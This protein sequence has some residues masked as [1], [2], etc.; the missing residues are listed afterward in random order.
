MEK[1]LETLCAEAERAVDNNI[2]IIIL[3]DRGVNRHLVPIPMLLATGAIHHHLI[4]A[5]KRMKV[6][7]ICETGEARDVH[8]FACLLGYGA[9]AVNPYL[10]LASLRNLCEQKIEVPNPALTEAEIAASHHRFL[11]AFKNY[12]KALDEGILK[13]M[14]KMGISTLTSYRGAQIF[15]AI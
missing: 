10:A 9:S 4:R 2:R 14:S 13:I 6:G 3:S 12:R 7:I 11:T 15:E 1:V 8:Q 5:G